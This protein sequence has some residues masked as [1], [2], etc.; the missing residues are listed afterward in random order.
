MQ[1][2]IKRQIVNDNPFVVA[3]LVNLAT[4]LTIRRKPLT[5]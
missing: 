2:K 5:P 4:L 3:L 1:R